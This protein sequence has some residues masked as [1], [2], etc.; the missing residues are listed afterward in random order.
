MQKFKE[1]HVRTAHAQDKDLSYRYYISVVENITFSCLSSS[2]H[3]PTNGIAANYALFYFSK[4]T[5]EFYAMG[6]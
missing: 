3:V 2:P 6:L 4:P 1:G 5:Q